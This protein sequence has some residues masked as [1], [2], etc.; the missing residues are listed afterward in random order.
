MIYDITQ[1]GLK[2]AQA[3]RV[4]CPDGWY[5]YGCYGLLTSEVFPTRHRIARWLSD[6]SDDNRVQS[7][8]FTFVK[9]R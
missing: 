1:N 4:M 9:V 7:D 8:D 3:V 6:N 2:I 5:L